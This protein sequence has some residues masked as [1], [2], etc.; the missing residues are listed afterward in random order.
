MSLFLVLPM[1]DIGFIIIHIFARGHLPTITQ[2]DIIYNTSNQVQDRD[3]R[4]IY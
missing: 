3:V 1:C 2:Y 4:T